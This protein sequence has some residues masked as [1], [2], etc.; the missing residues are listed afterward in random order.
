MLAL[1]KTALPGLFCRAD[2][3]CLFVCVV[4]QAV[5]LFV[6]WWAFCSDGFSVMIINGSYCLAIACWYVSKQICTVRQRIACI[7][8][9]SLSVLCFCSFVLLTVVS[10]C[11]ALVETTLVRPLK[12]TS[13]LS[14][15]LPGLGN[16]FL[17]SSRLQKCRP[18]MF[19]FGAE[20]AC[21]VCRFHQP[22]CEI[23]SQNTV[24]H[25][26]RD[27]CGTSVL[28]SQRSQLPFYEQQRPGA[29]PFYVCL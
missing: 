10:D 9:K 11:H 5:V 1:Y 16:P 2:F 8:R 26:V 7:V 29:A 4:A 12:A 25:I 28:S 27:Y 13:F 22:E 14:A 6:Q 19:A 21:S 18:S 20:S 23:T 3:R 24:P 17:D 15:F